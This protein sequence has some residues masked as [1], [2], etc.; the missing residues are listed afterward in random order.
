MFSHLSIWLM[1]QNLRQRDRSKF[2][3]L[4]KRQRCS[5]G[6]CWD[7]KK[8]SRMKHQKKR[9]EKRKHHPLPLCLVTNSTFSEASPVLRLL[10]IHRIQPFAISLLPYLFIK[11]IR[12]FLYPGKWELDNGLGGRN[13]ETRGC[14]L[15]L[16][17]FAYLFLSR[18]H[19]CSAS[20]F[21]SRSFA[22]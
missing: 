18:F 4:K 10:L 16:L 1:E 14:Y 8:P 13:K 22:F 7:P 6:S 2:W 5:Q 17:S 20:S 15:L 12:G 9:K 21:Q 19:S 11:A 3:Q